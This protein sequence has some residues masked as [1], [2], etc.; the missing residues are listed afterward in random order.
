ML[1]TVCAG[2]IL[3]FVS[4]YAPRVQRGQLSLK[5]R[6]LTTYQSSVTLLVDQAG[7]GL[8][9]VDSR[10]DVLSA[11][12]RSYAAV[13][14]SDLILDSVRLRLNGRLPAVTAE[15]QEN[16][17]LVR[18]V[19]EGAS[20]KAAAETANAV[21]TEFIA[22]IR[23][24]QTE[25]SIPREDRV[26]VSTLGRPSPGVPMQSRSAEIAILVFAVIL[27][28]GAAAALVLENVAR[29]ATAE[30]AGVIGPPVL[31]K[32]APSTPRV[33]QRSP[34][35]TSGQWETAAQ[36]ADRGAPTAVAKPAPAGASSGAAQQGAPPVVRDG[37]VRQQGSGDRSQRSPEGAAAATVSSSQGL[38][39]SRGIAETP[40]SGPAALQPGTASSRLPVSPQLRC[41]DQVSPDDGRRT[42]G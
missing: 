25:T 39:P 9:R 6:S 18:I 22:Y 30:R 8:G 15:A 11:M 17:P 34:A 14:Q 32:A 41:A 20:S 13:I 33:P 16:S 27:S 7:F 38:T 4:L 19:A 28:L 42:S 24:K 29:S 36:R 21:A 5:P 26:A 12:S 10:L 2:V 23:A 3:S 35:H 37:V 1:A 31:A 40:R